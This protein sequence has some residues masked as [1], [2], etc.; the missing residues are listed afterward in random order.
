MRCHDDVV[1]EK[2]PSSPLRVGL[3]RRSTV[4]NRTDDDDARDVASKTRTHHEE[5]T[6]LRIV[7]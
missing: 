3:Q 5:E 1:A 7:I 6:P 4:P 2:I